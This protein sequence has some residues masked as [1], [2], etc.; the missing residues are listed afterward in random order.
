MMGFGF[1]TPTVVT[2]IMNLFILPIAISVTHILWRLPLLIWFL[3]KILLL[4]LLLPLLQFIPHHIAKLPVCGIYF[5]ESLAIVTQDLFKVS[6]VTLLY[7]NNF[8]FI[9]NFIVWVFFSCLPN[10]IL[11][12]IINRP[13][14]FCLL[15]RKF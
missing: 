12:I 2:F 6:L 13:K 15:R 5:I 9:S 8:L 7:L 14:F 11:I 10:F 1:S 3:L 4:S